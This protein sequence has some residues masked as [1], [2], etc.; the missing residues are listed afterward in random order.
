MHALW[1][2]SSIFDIQGPSL[3]RGSLSTLG[4]SLALFNYKEVLKAAPIST[5]TV[6]EEDKIL[7]ILR[8]GNNIII[9]GVYCLIISSSWYCWSSPE[10]TKECVKMIF[11]CWMFPEVMGLNYLLYCSFLLALSIL[12]RT[13]SL[14]WQAIM[15]SI[16]SSKAYRTCWR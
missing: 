6:E 10:K 14:G 12:P 11:L 13:G 15:K 2:G 3:G 4:L 7:Y 16:S 9:Q 5:V 8:L 1:R